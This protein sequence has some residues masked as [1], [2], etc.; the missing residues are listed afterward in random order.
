MCVCVSQVRR[1][2]IET[3]INT[4]T[5]NG[6][7]AVCSVACP[8]KGEGEGTHTDTHTHTHGRDPCLS[9]L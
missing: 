2:D 7:K 8:G 3:G 4:D 1:W 5:Y 6:S 9:A